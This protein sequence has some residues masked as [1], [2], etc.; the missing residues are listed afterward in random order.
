MARQTP[1]HCD[2]CDEPSDDLKLKRMLHTLGPLAGVNILLRL[3]AG[4][5]PWELDYVCARCRG[6]DRIRSIIGAVIAIVIVVAS[7]AGTIWA[8]RAL[9]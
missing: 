9:P 1:T 5:P 4:Q 2:W 8:L 6:H 3:L 7:I